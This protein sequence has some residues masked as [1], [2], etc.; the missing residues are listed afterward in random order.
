M[1]YLEQLAAAARPTNH[2][3]WGS[4]RQIGAQNSFFDALDIA[5]SGRL[6]LAETEAFD[7]F[8]HKATTDEMIDE[9]LRLARLAASR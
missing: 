3:D 9:G 7:T 5:V 4:P 8:C 2:E 6:T 1:T